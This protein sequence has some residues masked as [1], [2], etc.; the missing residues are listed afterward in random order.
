MVIVC[1]ALPEKTMVGKRTMA[2]IIARIMAN[3]F[4]FSPCK[5]AVRIGCKGEK[6]Y[7]RLSATRP[8]GLNQA[9][10]FAPHL[11]RWFAL[12]EIHILKKQRTFQKS[13]L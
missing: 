4:I 5:P 12:I 11:H 10:S 3:R 1:G 9:L 7:Y 2:I 8:P 6:G 13:L